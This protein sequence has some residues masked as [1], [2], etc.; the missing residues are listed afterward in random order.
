MKALLAKIREILRNRKTRRLWV[1]VI[2][3]MACVVVFISTYALVLP[4]ITMEIEASCGIEAHQHT[5]ECYENVLVCGQ[6]ESEDHQ[7][8]DSC[9]EQVLACGKEEHIHSTECYKEETD[10]ET[11]A[12]ATTQAAS[13]SVILDS[14]EADAS[15]TENNGEEAVTGDSASSEGADSGDSYVDTTSEIENVPDETASDTDQYVPTLDPVYFNQVLNSRTGIYYY[16]VQ[17][18]E[19]IADSAEITDW[20]KI[21]Q[22]TADD[23]QLGK[24]DLLRVYLAYTIPAGSL[25]ETNEVARYRLPG[26]LHLTDEQVEAIN[27]TENGVAGQYIDYDTL[28]ILD[29]DNYYRYLGAEAV[30]GTRTPS[31]DIEKYLSK[32]GG[33]EYISAVVR[34]ENVYD[35]EGL[36]GEQG[37]YL[38]QDLV[39]TFTPYSIEKNRHQYDRDGQPTKAGEKLQGWFT[40]DFNM[41]QVD[42]VEGAEN[43]QTAEIIFSIEDRDLGMKEIRTD[44]TVADQ[45]SEMSDEDAETSDA[46]DDADEADPADAASTAEIVAADNSEEASTEETV[47]KSETAAEDKTDDNTT[48]EEAKADEAGYTAGTL[49]ADGDGYKITLDYT[50]EAQIP[51][52]ASLQVREITAET[53][54]EAYEACLKEAKEQVSTGDKET[55]DETATRFFDIE[56]VAPVTAAGSAENEADDTGKGAEAGKTQKIEPKAPVNVNIQLETVPASGSDTSGGDS[57]DQTLNPDPTVLHFAESGVEE[58]K[59]DTTA[60]KENDASAAI[61]FEAES[62]SI[63]GVVYTSTITKRY[64]SADG[65]SYDI[66]V[67]YNE[68]A[69]IPADADLNVREIGPETTEY[70]DYLRKSA[71]HLN[72]EDDSKE[73]TYNDISYARFFDIEITDREGQKIEPKTPVLVNI[74]YA[75]GAEIEAARDL[76]VVHFADNGTEVLEGIGVNQEGTVMTYL[77][78]GFSVTGTV[79]TNPAANDQYMVLIEY[80]GDYYIVN[81]DGSLTNVGSSATGSVE[82]DEPMMWTYDGRNIYH[83]TEQVSFNQ[84]QL[85][86]DFYNKYIDPTDRTD[87]ISTDKDNPGTRLRDINESY[88]DWNTWRMQTFT[89]QVIQNR[90]QQNVTQITLAGNKLKSANS[91]QYLGVVND[92]GVLKLVGGVSAADAATV[93]LASANEVL[94]TNYLNHTVNHIDISIE[95]DAT[96]DVPLAYGTYQ[97]YN[98][99]TNQM[100]EFTVEEATTLELNSGVVGITMDDMKRAIITAYKKNPDGSTEELDNAFVV[101]GYSANSPTAYST[102]QVRIEG[103]FRVS[104]MD[105]VSQ[106]YYNQHRDQVWAERLQKKIY[107]KVTAYKTITFNMIDP[108]KGQ[109]YDHDGNPLTVN[110]DVAFSASFD[111]WDQRNECPPVQWDQ[112]WLNGKGTIPDHNLSGMDFVLGGNGEGNAISRAVEIRKIIEDENGSPI[113]LQS[114]LDHSF[115]LYY[116][117][118]NTSSVTSHGTASNLRNSEKIWKIGSDAYNNYDPTTDKYTSGS[119]AGKNKFVKAQNVGVRVGTSGVGQSYTYDYN[120]GVFYIREDTSKVPETITDADGETW[121]YTS[122][123]IETEYARRGATGIE[124]Y[125]YSQKINHTS[126]TYTGLTD[127]YYSRAEVLGLYQNQL[128]QP[129]NDDNTYDPK[130][131]PGTPADNEFLEFT[132]HNI[133][134]N[135]KA[136]TTEL[137][138]TKDWDGEEGDATEVYVKV[139]RKTADGEPEDFTDVIKNDAENLRLYIDHSRNFDANNGWIIVH[140]N[141]GEGETGWDTVTLKDVPMTTVADPVNQTEEEPYTYYIKEVGYK[142]AEGKVYRNVDHFNPEYATYQTTD[143]EWQPMPAEGI[144]LE[145]L[146]EGQDVVNRFKVTNKQEEPVTTSYTVTKAFEGGYPTDGSVQVLVRLEEGYLTDNSASGSGAPTNWTDTGEEVITLP[147]PYSENTDSSITSERDWYASPAAWTYTWDNLNAKKKVNGEEITLWY[148]AKEIS[149]PEWFTVVNPDGEQVRLP[150]NPEVTTAPGLTGTVTNS[151]SQYELS[152]DKQWAK[153]GKPTTWPAGVTIDAN[154]V[155]YW[156]LAEA[157]DASNPSAFAPG[158][159]FRTETLTGAGYE[160]SLTGTK[161]SDTF[162]NLPAYG[163]IGGNSGNAITDEMIVEARKAGITLDR[164]RKYLVIYT[165][166]AIETRIHWTSADG[167][168][169]QIDLTVPGTQDGNTFT[170]SITN[171]LTDLIVKKQWRKSGGQNDGTWPE[172]A[173]VNYKVMRVP[174][175]TTESGKKVELDAQDYTAHLSGYAPLTESNFPDGVS[176]TN[177]PVQGAET[178]P[179]SNKYGLV[180]GTYLVSY[181]Y[182]VEEDPTGDSSGSGANQTAPPTDSAYQYTAV[183]AEVINGVATL[184]NEYTEITIDKKWIKKNSSGADITAPFPAGFKVNWKVVQKDSD[185]N[186]INSDFY[187]GYTG[188]EEG[189][190]GYHADHRL[191]Q[192]S[193]SYTL[194]YLPAKGIANGKEVDFTYEVYELPEGSEAGTGNTYLFQMI[195]AKEGEGENAGK[196]TIVNDLTRVTVEKTGDK[197]KSVVVQLYASSEKP[198]TLETVDVKVTLDQWGTDSWGNDRIPLD[199]GEITGVLS[200]S[201]GSSRTFTLRPGDNWTAIFAG[202]PKYKSDG[203]TKIVYSIESGDYPI[204]GSSPIQNATVSG[205]NE[206]LTG[207]D[208]TIHLQAEGEENSV[209]FRFVHGENWPD[210]DIWETWNPNDRWQIQIQITDSNGNAVQDTNGETWLRSFAPNETEE[211]SPVL[212]AGTYTIQYSF[213]KTHTNYELSTKQEVSTNEKGVVT[214]EI[215]LVDTRPAFV[216]TVSGWPDNVDPDD[217]IWVQV[218]QN[219]N[220][221][222]VDGTTTYFLTP[223]SPSVRVPLDAG[224]YH[225]QY[226]INNTGHTLD[227]FVFSVNS[228]TQYDLTNSVNLDRDIEVP[229]QLE[230]KNGPD[231]NQIQVDFV[232]KEWL[233]AGNIHYNGQIPDNTSFVISLA[234]NYGSVTLG[235]GNWTKS[236][237]LDKK[238]GN[239]QTIYY[240]VNNTATG[241]DSSIVKQV[242]IDTLNFSEG[243]ANSNGVVTI[244]IRVALTNAYIN[245]QTASLNLEKEAPTLLAQTPFLMKANENH[246]DVPIAA[247]TEPLPGTTG[248]HEITVVDKSNLP[249]GAVA[250]GDE[251]TLDDTNSPTAWKYTW[252]NLPRVDVNGN[253]IYYY[254]VEKSATTDVE[255]VTSTTATYVVNQDPNTG[256]FTITIN[257]KTTSEPPKT[258]TIEVEKTLEGLKGDDIKFQFSLR[259][260]TKNQYLNS[261]GQWVTSEEAAWHDIYPGQKYTFT[262]LPLGNYVLKEK[263]AGTAI[264]GYVLDETQSITG[265]A[266]T[267]ISVIA[268]GT[269]SF[270]FKNVYKPAPIRVIKKWKHGEDEIEA[271][272]GAKVTFRISRS[273]NEPVV[274]VNG[275]EVSDIILDGTADDKGE[276]AA[277]VAEWKNLPRQTTDGTAITYTITELTDEDGYSWEHFKVVGDGNI[278]YSDSSP[279]DNVITN[280]E[281]T[282]QIK[283]T[284][285]WNNSNGSEKSASELD[286]K[287]IQFTLYQT[288]TDKDGNRHPLVYTFAKQKVDGTSTDP[289]DLVNG[290]GEVQYITTGSGSGMTGSWQTIVISDLPE[291][292]RGEDGDWYDS[293]YY[294]E[295]DGIANVSTLY[296][297]NGTGGSDQPG[298]AAASNDGDITIVNTDDTTSLKVEKTWDDLGT[299]T[300]YTIRFKLQ[301][302]LATQDETAWTDETE[303]NETT[304]KTYEMAFNGST[305]SIRKTSGTEETYISNIIQPLDAGRQYRVVETAYQVKS[306]DGEILI[307]EQDSADPGSSSN[308]EWMPVSV[309]GTSVSTDYGRTWTS[310]LENRLEKI[311]KIDGKKIWKDDKES[312]TDPRLILERTV[313]DWS[314]VEQVTALKLDPTVPKTAPTGENVGTDESSYTYLY[315]VWSTES[316]FRQYT[317]NNL[318]KYNPQGLE[319]SYRVKEVPPPGYQPTYVVDGQADN[320]EAGAAI[321]N[322]TGE[323]TVNIVNEPKGKLKVKKVWFAGATDEQMKTIQFKLEKSYD[324]ETWMPVQ[325][326]GTIGSGD[327]VAASPSDVNGIVTLAPQSVDST[328]LEGNT[329]TM[330]SRTWEWISGD[331]PRYEEDPANSG[332]YKHVYYRVYETA[333]DGTTVSSEYHSGTIEQLGWKITNPE[334]VELTVSSDQEVTIKNDKDYISVSGTK[335]WVTKDPTRI[336]DHLDLKLYTWTETTDPDTNV[337]TASAE[338]EVQVK[339]ADQVSAGSLEPRLTWYI[340][341]GSTV[342]TYAYTYLPKSGTPNQV[343]RYRVE[344]VMD[345]ELRNSFTEEMTPGQTTEKG[346]IT[347]W[348]FVNTEKTSI[349]V[350]KKWIVNE[351]EVDGDPF[352]TNRTVK[353]ELIRKEGSTTTSLGEFELKKTPT[354]ISASAEAASADDELSGTGGSGDQGGDSQSGSGSSGTSGGQGDQNDQGGQTQEGGNNVSGNDW[355]L[356]IT[357]LAKYYQDS[358]GAL[359]NYTYYVIEHDTGIWHVEYYMDDTSLTDK[360]VVPNRMEATG[361]DTPIYVENS[362]Y[363]VELPASG[364]PGTRLIYLVG[365]M[366]TGLGLLLL[367]R[368]RIL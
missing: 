133:Y 239:N 243:N 189:A 222:L 84:S 165:Y 363:T 323:A 171:E 198:G 173:V 180:G 319:Y 139:F 268:N 121:Y 111:F 41:D 63:Y 270:E 138:V 346:D 91:E 98:P 191:Q 204:T 275:T 35:E 142:D 279:A 312:H 361:E 43:Q 156:H 168:Y 208:Y 218:L 226:G 79:V 209:Q 45:N 76:H 50:A 27:S 12:V 178:L 354:I 157:D 53:D 240:Q 246:A 92:H 60:D 229:I 55:V 311:R 315:P 294:V 217:N 17:P 265:T 54:K 95:G 336:P 278:T 368:K 197:G 274:D 223:D 40:L 263:S 66:T 254:V 350:I 9:Y 78:D 328:D 14:G 18:D 51:E 145:S 276:A 7:H 127:N 291:K 220:W 47:D 160:T 307:P 83:H 58:L 89:Y 302:K 258:G 248:E 164:E 303:Q 306:A 316:G 126:A 337:V 149:V 199:S 280:Q 207:N 343:I 317:Y 297:L 261:S 269:S 344:E 364:G 304:V 234:N 10:S 356:T 166:G 175:I 176:F 26:N 159:V 288:Y 211:M 241:I 31:D 309:N 167:D 11:T 141:T 131:G 195:Q 4:A 282:A 235:N 72:E 135:T 100:E 231:E 188:L 105:P 329:T 107:Y 251:I 277:W 271:P 81:N 351:E 257:N 212:P 196:F 285:R 77:Q 122:T 150:A 249:E 75:D 324:Q 37:A 134:K 365:A 201:D 284:K 237:Y 184:T 8:T 215:D 360:T 13:G 115:E 341:E 161:T 108:E 357:D 367:R 314:T 106:Q 300:P 67:V 39:F 112:D 179:P 262:N 310:R 301:S 49:T 308:E 130:Y 255:G 362:T 56:I 340:Q 80:E 85:A 216:F 326:V 333:I 44:L 71:D 272:A 113:A 295:E 219:G 140:K 293:R 15:A 224:S 90:P 325:T 24:G 61:Q 320:Q 339:P 69:G 99:T 181:R 64:L 245:S 151:P 20:K 345:E 59:S 118:D 190:D 169:T 74:E 182:Y 103:E 205:S 23:T 2:S 132:V 242:F 154:V 332:T 349:K 305:Y 331:L 38:G 46:A 342:W 68:D 104:Y 289:T 203:T 338:S 273:D 174:I 158:V 358:E 170:S 321:I 352:D 146:T 3:L 153:D 281:Q 186:I 185:G 286:G 152:V 119:N 16:H 86:A 298:D 143:E 287:S 110:V 244:P 136:E 155:R 162:H 366:L 177:L 322:D 194:K 353:I 70:V 318:P 30:E 355:E 335:T 87:G 256:E 62:F 57:G 247:P 34:V 88:F 144:A 200:G 96:V 193:D 124:T 299:T 6:E 32:H 65:T 192:G 236:L 5:D 296:Q 348:N 183:T 21:E 267:G 232:V 101:N 82:V 221:N 42:L 233:D 292:V 123:V 330:T 359:Q 129:T 266:G 25:N 334:P 114:S 137:N 73:I 116:Y 19:T 230:E 264:S 52:N 117:P 109:L 259:S 347:N 225:Y 36:Y 128:E 120:S 253:P 48:A 102:Q 252:D 206:A 238:D 163:Y 172:G 97:Y 22:N 260:V 327:N 214:K 94:R 250:V 93:R 210:G 313:D 227:G 213:T 283:V 29:T 28:E 202:L 147:R 33:Q 290:K 187:K 228:S 125:P 1:R 148:R